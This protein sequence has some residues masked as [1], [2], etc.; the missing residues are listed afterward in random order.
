MT[1]LELSERY[2]FDCGLPVLRSHFPELAARCAAGL[3]STGSEVYG[4]DDSISRDHNWG[5][6]FILFLS[7][8]DFQRQG[9][10]VQRVLDQELP[11]EYAGT[12]IRRTG[13]AFPTSPAPVVTPA[14]S[15]K[16]NTGFPA[17]PQDDRQ[18]LAIPEHR[19]FEFTAGRIFH[20]P[21]PLIT[22]IREAFAYFP[23]AVWRK[24]LSFA[25]FA[26]SH[27]ANVARTARRGDVLASHAYLA[28][29]VECCARLV[30]L[31]NR[32]YAPFRKW[33]FHGLRLLPNLPTGLLQEMERAVT[34]VS[35]D[36]AQESLLRVLDSVGGLANDA[37]LV[38]RQPLRV[39]RQDVFLPF[40]FEGST[41]AFGATV[42]GPLKEMHPHDGPLDLRGSVFWFPR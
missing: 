20:E 12:G 19:L 42:T 30:H 2:F 1:G 36:Q 17:A 26:A 31:L 25:W 21:V 35:L 22:P 11:R 27:C 9:Q 5:P 29:G 3:I 28:W 8:S 14:A 34:S 4:W 41:T 23:D 40:N 37:Q 10:A 15:A 6:R 32:R 13:D 38:P 7:D 33:L 16:W 24:R 18:W 39:S